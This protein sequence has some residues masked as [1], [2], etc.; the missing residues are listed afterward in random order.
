V[1]TAAKKILAE[2]AEGDMLRTQMTILRRLVKFDPLN[3]IAAREKIAAR[4]LEAGK[5]S[6]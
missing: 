1:E 3:V 5:Y 6:F 2:V 4:V